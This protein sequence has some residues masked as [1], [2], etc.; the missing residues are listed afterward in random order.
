LE[1]GL[2]ITNSYA[3]LSGLKDRLGIAGTD[4]DDDVALEYVIESVSR[5]IDE[6]C[7][8]R[9][10]TAA[11]TRYFTAEHSEVVYPGDFTALTALYTDDDGD[12]AYEYTWAATDYDLEPYNAALDGK[13]YTAIRITPDGDY[14][15]PVGVPKGVKV[16]ATFGYASTAPSAVREACLIQAQRIWKRHDAPFGV[17]GSGEFGTVTLVPKI[18]PDVKALLWPYMKLGMGAI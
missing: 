17:A 5:W 15:F 8:R 3:T 4:T 13:P 16:T 9:F 7:A 11:E 12:H 2:S 10:Y 18:D 14:S 1:V 6:L